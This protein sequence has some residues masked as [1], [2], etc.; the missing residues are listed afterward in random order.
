MDT[1]FSKLQFRFGHWLAI[2]MVLCLP[3]RLP[4]HD[5]WIEPDS[6]RPASGS[7]VS[8]RLREGVGFKGTTLPYINEW[9]QDFS[10]VT[11]DGREPVIS[12]RGDDPA[13]TL[14]MP[15]G[16]MLIGYQS[17]RAFTEL[18][19]EK[20][21]RYLEEEGIEFIREQRIAAG[22]D[23][24]PA[25]EFFVRCAKALLQAGPDDSLVYAERLGY[26]LELV[27]AANPYS[28][29]PGDSLVFTLYL[30]DEPVEGL[31]VQAFNRNDPEQIQK[32]RTDAKGQATV[33][34]DQAGEW[35][36]KAVNIQPLVGSPQANWLSHWASYGF[37]LP[38][39]AAAQSR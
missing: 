11:A 23:Q 36:V 2:A 7:E 38:A 17:N 5:F 39:R 1:L 4:A 29:Q 18:A 10:V 33:V 25:P 14:T 37:A 30:R 19:A 27:P 15:A 28:L 8:V 3:S 6:Y 16:P 35:L 26:R 9:F 22:T 21:N 32:I 12:W 24:Q 20:F 13:A 34:L 31:L